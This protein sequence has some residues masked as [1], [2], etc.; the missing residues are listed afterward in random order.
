MSLPRYKSVAEE[1]N[2]YGTR[3]LINQMVLQMVIRAIAHQ[4]KPATHGFSCIP[5]PPEWGAGCDLLGRQCPRS[6]GRLRGDQGHQTASAARQQTVVSTWCAGTRHCL[7]G[8][9]ALSCTARQ[10]TTNRLH[11]H[12]ATQLVCT[13]SCRPHQPCQQVVHVMLYLSQS[14]H[15]GSSNKKQTCHQGNQHGWLTLRK[16]NGSLAACCWVV[17]ND[18]PPGEGLGEPEAELWSKD[19]L[20][21]RAPRHESMFHFAMDPACKKKQDS[22]RSCCH[23]WGLGQA[24]VSAG[25]STASQPSWQRTQPVSAMATSTLSQLFWEVASREAALQ[26]ARSAPGGRGAVQGCRPPHA[27]CTVQH[28]R[29]FSL[30]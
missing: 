23:A 14:A 22:G 8:S 26:T 5:G 28:C 19:L 21:V 2:F 20:L 13:H 29:L 7:A 18:A 24:S 16:M 3:Q 12:M 15:T 17:L 1:C 4:V 10:G 25:S 9:A 27:N 11:R 30:P 6:V